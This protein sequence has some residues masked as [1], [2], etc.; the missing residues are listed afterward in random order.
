MRSEDDSGKTE[1]FWKVDFADSGDTLDS[2]DTL[3]SNSSHNVS[4]SGPSEPAAPRAMRV[5]ERLFPDGITRLGTDLKLAETIG[6]GGAAV[7]RR[8]EQLALGRDVAVKML[9]PRKRTERAISALLHEAWITG[10]LEHPNVVPIYDIVIDDD[11]HPLIVLKRIE[12]RAWSELIGDGRAVRKQFGAEDLLEW[13]LRIL[14]QVLS[15]V[16]FAHSRGIVHRDLKPDNVMIGEFG[17]VYV[18]D[19]GLAVSLRDD[20]TGRLPLATNT[21]SLVGT[22]GY[23]APE[24]LS[25]SA[26][27]LSERTDIYLAGAI[28]HEILTGRPPHTGTNAMAIIASAI[29]SSPVFAEDTPQRLVRI[30][31]R[32]MDAEPHGRFESAE[33]M[34]LAVSGFLRNRGSERLAERA[35]ASLVELRAALHRAGAGDAEERQHLYRLYGAC[36]F[37]FREALSAW[38][39]NEQAHRGVEQAALA[40]IEYELAQ[41]DAR[42]ADALCAELSRPPAELR[43][44]IERTIAAHSAERQQ[45]AQLAQ[46]GQQ[47]D[48]RVGQRSRALATLALGLFFTVTPSLSAWQWPTTS[49]DSHLKIILW[50]TAFGLFTL[51]VG[52]R[53][54]GA[55]RQSAANR[56]LFTMLL[57]LIATAFPLQFGLWRSGLSASESLVVHEF[58]WAMLA[59]IVAY[60]FDLRLLPAALAYLTTFLII[61]LIPEWRLYVFNLPHGV[62]TINYVVVWGWMR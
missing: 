22:P 49:F 9:K 62:L 55:L 33:Q 20:E 36:R 30:C 56:R 50:A 13:N 44:R 43:Q 6:S 7:V 12:G 17:E 23:M 4:G 53:I 27:P 51:A 32:A 26:I 31:R 57:L 34:R 16:G 42:A 41:G 19:W 58:I 37:G 38:D 10:S 61:A 52:W 28:L 45:M 59:A 48:V 29:R 5:F 15:A 11:G 46:L 39:G 24:M 60:T 40:M 21:T 2:R 1:K 8:A 54:R 47:L 35:E 14:M 3:D 25:D 18:V